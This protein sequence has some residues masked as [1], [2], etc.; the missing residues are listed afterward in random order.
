MKMCRAWFG[1]IR[2][3]ETKW[4]FTCRE[5]LVLDVSSARP[6]DNE[7]FQILIV[8]YF[9]FNVKINLACP[10]SVFKTSIDM[11]ENAKK[12]AQLVKKAKKVLQAF[13]ISSREMELVAVTW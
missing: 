11:G 10:N 9:I 1:G 7:G 3:S 2:I 12:I 13:S 5:N 6:F 8:Y 4:D